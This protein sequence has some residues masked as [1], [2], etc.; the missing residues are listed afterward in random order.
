MT[1]LGFP[2]EPEVNRNFA[3]VSGVTL[4]LRGGDAGVVFGADEV[5][6]QRRLAVCRR[7]A[8]DHQF[9]VARQRRRDGAPERAAV[10]GEHH[11]GRQQVDDGAQLAEVGRQQ[12]IGRR[13]RR[14]GNADAHRRQRQQ[15]VFDV[16][17]GNDRDRLV[18][19]E[20]AAQERCAD[21]PGQRQHLRIAQRA[22]VALRVALAEEHAV[23]RGLGPVF[24][25]L[26]QRGVIG[27]EHL[28]G[29]DM[30]DAARLALQHGV[31]FAQPYRTQGR[32][33]AQ[34]GR[35]CR[36]CAHVGSRVTLGARFSRKSLS[37]ALASPSACAIDDISASTA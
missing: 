10:T 16:V 27:R 26:A 17:A 13:D 1:P 32:R 15:R 31:E 9:G 30:D 7:I 2:V 4:A 12:R 11:A 6:E 37:R 25:R 8:G 34:S 14:I 21:A 5:V 24:Q 3:M 28:R 35:R 19:R 18:R 33:R 36:H 29:A 20:P 22:P 23:G